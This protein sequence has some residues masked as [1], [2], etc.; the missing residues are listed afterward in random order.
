MFTVANAVRALLEA[1]SFAAVYSKTVSPASNYTTKA[2]LEDLG[3]KRI[4]VAPFGRQMSFTNRAA[5]IRYE[6]NIDIVLRYRFAASEYSSGELSD[7]AVDEYVQLLEEL[8]EYLARPAR[9]RLFSASATFLRSEVILP[10]AADHL[11]EGQYTGI[12]RATYEQ[13]ATL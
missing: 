4:D 6:H 7:D 3:T 5:S 9:R 8:E 1:G 12:F 2:L 10:Y 11:V 13:H